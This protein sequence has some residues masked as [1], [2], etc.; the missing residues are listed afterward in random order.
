M[1]TVSALRAVGTSATPEQIRDWIAS[2]K[3]YAGI[4]GVYDFKDLDPHGLSA[5]DA[6]IFRW[7]PDKTSFVAVSK[8]GGYL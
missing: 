1:I 5:K 2:Q 8:F 6:L 7:D 4:T 3:S